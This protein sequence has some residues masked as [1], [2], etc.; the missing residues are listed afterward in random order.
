MFKDDS[1]I[2]ILSGI[3]LLIA[4]GTII[5]RADGIAEMFGAEPVEIVLVEDAVSTADP[6]LLQIDVLANDTG[7][8]RRHRDMLVIVDGPDCGQVFIQDG[9]L[10]Y[11][12]TAGC[13]AEQTLRYSIKE[14]E[15]AE[16]GTVRV[17]LTYVPPEVEDVIA[18]APITADVS[19]TT[20]LNVA[21][22]ATGTPATSA[23][24]QGA[25]PSASANPLS[26]DYDIANDADAEFYPPVEPQVPAS[27]YASSYEEIAGTDDEPT[28][29]EPNDTAIAASQPAPA[30]STAA[31]SV[32]PVPTNF[33]TLAS[34]LLTGP[35]PEAA[36]DRS[37]DDALAPG[38]AS[39]STRDGDPGGLPV[40]DLAR[41]SVSDDDTSADL[42]STTAPSAPGADTST[43]E[44]LAA[45]SQSTGEP[46]GTV[47]TPDD[48][49]EALVSLDTGATPN[50][51]LEVTASAPPVGIE[52]RAPLGA[53]PGRPSAPTVEGDSDGGIRTA[54]LASDGGAPS[55]N[56]QPV[57]F[58]EFSASVVERP[59]PATVAP[60]RPRLSDLGGTLPASPGSGTPP[61]LTP[62]Q[63]A[64]V[65]L[66]TPGG[67]TEQTPVPDQTLALA[68]TD[69]AETP[70]PPPP[71]QGT[72]SEPE[73]I[74]VTSRDITISL[75][76][77]EGSQSVPLVDTPE[78]LTESEAG[79]RLAALTPP[80]ASCV[81]PPS[82]TL[83]VK[84]AAETEIYVTAPCHANTSAE[85]TYSG[86]NLAIP[87]DREGK[88]ALLA[89][90]FDPSAAAQITFNGGEKLDFDLPFKDAD[91][92][93][94]IALVWGMPVALELNA[95]EFGAGS[96]SQD[97][98][99]PEN[100]RDFDAVRR[101]GG[102]YLRTYRAYAGVGQNAQIYTHWHKRGGKSGIVRLMIDF[103]SRNRDRLIETCGS[104]RY[105]AP[106][107]SIIR[108]EN[109]QL[110]RPTTRRLAALA[111]ELV[112][113]EIGDN[114]LIS[115][116][117]E[118]L[119]VVER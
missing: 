75:A 88:G 62:E 17:N 60:A 20:D 15:I 90:G 41:E 69:S 117:V 47:P 65:A 44:R 87:L 102:G 66:V 106:E 85:L 107:F 103:A 113:E 38:G 104:G 67:A 48:E 118:D 112:P 97:H 101:A 68:P 2:S 6:T 59:E 84:R 74:R 14:E 76:P 56:D 99:N 116:A 108:A 78:A 10:Q 115:G 9:T 37:R 35:T 4:V 91:R 21:T 96:G 77:N 34:N 100:P 25:A 1:M 11:L 40:G 109:G 82:M 27:D 18:A 16:P 7:V 3:V 30:E 36:I 70:P 64:E 49:G 95:L 33:P 80:D 29:S 8:T 50:G 42:P 23:A 71:S 61:T 86:L 58:G 114:R 79:E 24:V 94:R 105:A 28:A 52:T 81:Q 5:Q 93:S 26:D 22:T 51:S 32:E 55:T 63:D 89:L 110:E 83:N 19:E 72:P 46:L 92:V 39:E 73:P 43:P 31:S 45:T 111:C 12:P 98:V 119:V 13:A 53:V 54:G 57:S